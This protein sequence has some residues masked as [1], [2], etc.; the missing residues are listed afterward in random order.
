MN[1]IALVVSVAAFAVSSV[2]AIKQLRSA[3]VANN[4]VVTIE[5]LAREWRTEEFLESEDYVLNKLT[6]EHSPNQGTSGLPFEARKHVTRFA[7]FYS[8]LGMMWVFNAVD[9]SLIMSTVSY[10]VQ[11]A[12]IALE[13]Y[14]MT[15]R[16]MGR[17]AYLTFFEHLA[18][19]A[20]EADTVQ[21]QKSLGLRTFRPPSEGY[22]QA[23]PARKE[24]PNTQESQGIGPPSK[25]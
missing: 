14:I 3:R 12:W 9:K 21:L 17:P 10:R 16:R 2:F 18:C 19:V 22:G 4:T 20:S 15:E 1:V 13:P 23:I 7:Q 6:K 25:S 11:A 5:L 8:S 24:T